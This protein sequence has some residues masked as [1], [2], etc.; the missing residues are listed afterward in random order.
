MMLLNNSTDYM[1]TSKAAQ[2]LEMTLVPM[3]AI[4]GVPSPRVLNTH[5]PFCHLPPDSIKKR[6]KIIYLV[7]NH[8]DVAVSYYNHTRNIKMYEYEGSWNAFLELFAKGLCK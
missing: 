2:M 3:S 1:K 4:T 8:K 7:R 6:S 5:L